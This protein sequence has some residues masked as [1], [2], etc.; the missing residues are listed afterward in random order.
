MKALYFLLL[1]LI[2]ILNATI[3]LMVLRRLDGLR[4]SVPPDALEMAEGL[5]ATRSQ[6]TPG[7]AVLAKNRLELIPATGQPATIFLSD[8]ESVKEV[9]WF[10]GKRLWWKRGMKI[11]CRNAPA[12]LLALAGPVFLRW[13]PFLTGE[14][15]RLESV[16]PRTTEAASSE[17]QS[18]SPSAAPQYNSWERTIVFGA[19]IFFVVMFFV[20]FGVALEFPRQAAA[21]LTVMGMCVIG[22]GVCGLRLA[23]FW[24]FPSPR[25]PQ[26]NFSSRNLSC[27]SSS[28]QMPACFALF[29]AGLSGFLGAVTF[30]FWPNPPAGL[31]WSIPVAALLGIFLGISARAHR[32]GKRAT[33]IGGVNAAIWLAVALAVNSTPFKIHVRELALTQWP[34][35]VV[36]QTIQHEIRTPVAGSRRHV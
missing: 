5:I 12:I 18:R 36:A 26:P 20:V 17:E 21:P 9:R 35:K 3:Y 24:P 19:T 15:S 11:Q 33:A 7:L 30:C 1:E 16:P 25:F 8:I 28:G 10:N 14:C 29:F 27:G 31:V 34:D 4:G 13:K 23:G 22:L 6:Q 2:P 32:S